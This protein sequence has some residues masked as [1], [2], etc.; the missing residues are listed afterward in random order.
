MPK[1][2]LFVASQD[3]VSHTAAAVAAGAAEA[4]GG[5]GRS[6]IRGVVK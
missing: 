2:V 5:A 4:A 3:I 6:G 1:G